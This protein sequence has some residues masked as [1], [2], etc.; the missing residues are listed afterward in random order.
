MRVLIDARIVNVA[1]AD[2]GGELL[3]LVFAARKEMPALRCGW[4]MPIVAAKID[5]LDLRGVFRFFAGIDAD[6][7]DLVVFSQIEIHDAERAGHAVQDFS[8]EHRAA[9]VDEREDHR[10]LLTEEVPEAD[11]FPGLITELEI[12]WKLLVQVLIDS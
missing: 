7:N 11:V 4:G 2:G 8:A 3:D 1:E 5:F 6:G 12:E 10:T 9:V